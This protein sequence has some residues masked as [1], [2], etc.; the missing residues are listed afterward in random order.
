MDTQVQRVMEWRDQKRQ[1]GYQSRTVWLTTEVNHLI[2]DLAAQLRQDPAQVVS[3]AVREYAARVYATGESVKPLP[4]YA[5]VPTVLRLIE[6]H[7]SRQAPSV[8]PHEP[9]PTEAETRSPALLPGEHGAISQAIRQ[10]APQLPRFTAA[11]MARHVGC[12]LAQAHGALKNL[13]KNG[14]LA[15]SGTVYRWTGADPPPPRLHNHLRLSPAQ[16]QQAVAMA[17]SGKP[18]TKIAETLGCAPNTVARALRRAGV[19]D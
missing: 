10:A 18:I 17:K 9:A 11:T 12:T 15:K 1:A 7:M 19:K 8:P 13:V 4:E 6:E 16:H 3:A 5:D 14:E 2:T